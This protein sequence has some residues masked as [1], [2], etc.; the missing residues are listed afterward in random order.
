MSSKS[1]RGLGRGIE[2]LFIENNEINL[3]KS[4]NNN[5]LDFVAIELLEPNPFQPRKHFSKDSL[6]D[7]SDSIKDRGI[8]QPIIVRPKKN[9]ANAWQIIAGERRWRAAQLVG[10]HEVPVYIKNVKDEEV[11]IIALIENIQRED[12]SPIEEAKG[13]KKVMQKFSIT[14]EELAV[15]MRRSRSYVTNFIRLLNLPKEV[16]TLIEEK[17][18]SI[19]QARPI[20]GHK[21]TI[22][23]ARRIVKDN[24]NARQV[25]LLVKDKKINREDSKNI[26]D[27]NIRSLENEIEEIIGLKT[28]IKDKNGKGQIIFYYKDLEQLE[29]IIKKVKK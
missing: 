11:A 14:Q 28:T 15:T 23:L 25:E 17:K 13:Y 24:L 16:Q 21:N 12:L 8:L 5:L 1:K 4:I 20:I 9:K 2:A 27:V 18:I 22:E 6:R 3:N 19:G 29:E 10:L 7:L 26:I